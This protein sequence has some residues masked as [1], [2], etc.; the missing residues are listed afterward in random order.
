MNTIRGTLNE[1]VGNLNSITGSLK[2][3][4]ANPEAALRGIVDCVD[5]YAGA[6]ACTGSGQGSFGPMLAG[7]MQISTGVFEAIGACET[8]DKRR[9]F[10]GLGDV[11][12]GLG[13]MGVAEGCMAMCPIGVLGLVISNVA[14]LTGSQKAG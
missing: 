12:T 5:L 10:I 4:L 11:L 9:S 2:S 6:Y 1:G 3:K 13:L 7:S 8:G 14:T